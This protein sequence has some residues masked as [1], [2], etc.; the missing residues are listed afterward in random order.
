MFEILEYPVDSASLN[1]GKEV[2]GSVEVNFLDESGISVDISLISFL[3]YDIATKTL[4]VQ[5]YS[6]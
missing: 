3:T 6:Y 4:A 1:A 2:C 5:S